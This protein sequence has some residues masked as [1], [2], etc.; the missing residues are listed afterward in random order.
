MTQ[1]TI[2]EKGYHSWDGQLLPSTFQW[3]P[4]FLNGTK[5]VFK[6]KYAK[7]LFVFTISP[8]LLFLLGIW[9]SIR[10]ELDMVPFLVRLLKNEAAFFNT[11]LTNGYSIFMLVLL[12]S[13]FGAELI[14]RDIKL[15]SFPLYFSRP[16]DRKD[17][18]FGK[19]S[20]IMFYYLLFTMMPG[21]LLYT[22]KFIFT[23]KISIDLHI[24]NALIFLPLLISFFIASITLLVS[25]LSSNTKYVKIIIF[26]IY[27][28]SNLIANILTEIFGSPYFNL[29]SIQN[30]I[31][32]MGSYMFITGDKYYS[33]GWLSPLVVTTLTIGA[34]LILDKRIG[35]SEAQIE[36]GN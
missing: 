21:M 34:C 25:S 10:P 17:Y 16:L 9:V 27:I 23:G 12:G 35:K 3:L 15:N 4:I 19:L 24:L 30:N 2:R 32:R 8:F 28:F 22:F 14:S 33:L 13:F 6:K 7:V 26:A 11:F 1:I 31:E 20:I 18:I 5:T 36:S 29:I